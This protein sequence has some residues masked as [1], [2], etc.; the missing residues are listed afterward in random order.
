MKDA[1]NIVLGIA[2]LTFILWCGIYVGKYN[3]MCRWQDEAV[4]KGLGE[5]AIEYDGKYENLR[6]VFR[7]KIK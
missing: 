5:Y 1:F 2:A 4:A 3:E 6:R 7:W